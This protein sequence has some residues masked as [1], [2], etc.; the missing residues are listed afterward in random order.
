M[1][2]VR[3]TLTAEGFDEVT[4]IGFCGAPWT[5][6]CYM[7]EGG[8]SRDFEKARHWAAQD[9]VSFQKLVD[10]VTD[11]SIEYLSGQVE[12]GAEALQI[13][14][15]WGG[16]LDPDQFRRWVISPTQ[17]IVVALKKKYPAIPIIGFP[18]GAGTL[19]LD[20][21]KETGIDAISLD[22]T[23]DPQ[24]AAQHLQPIIPVQGNLDP[25]RLLS[26]GDALEEG[27]KSIYTAFAGKPFIFNL[28]HGV[29]KETEIAHVERLTKIVRGWSV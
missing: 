5:V 21:A 7:I 10:I 29:I 8:G 27:M 26:G 13:F 6:I 16:I 24:W 15:S 14:E 18:R 9:P 25:V 22:Y 23:I 20:Y 3:E 11:A 4:L 28:G 1:R 17:K 19:C 12:A 2:K